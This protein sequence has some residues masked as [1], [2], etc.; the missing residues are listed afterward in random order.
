MRGSEG[1]VSVDIPFCPDLVGGA[2]S[3]S[4]AYVLSAL[5]RCGGRYAL[6]GELRSVR[7]VLWRKTGVLISL[8]NLS[9]N[10]PALAPY[11]QQ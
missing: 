8:E 2:L 10:H 4:G 7:L 6:F 11:L 3:L 1:H 9:W 5:C